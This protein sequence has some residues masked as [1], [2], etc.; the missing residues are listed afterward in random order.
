MI[1][2][3]PFPIS[4]EANDGEYSFDDNEIFIIFEVVSGG[5][6]KVDEG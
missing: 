1:E 4:V 3:K 5:P 6:N 2:K